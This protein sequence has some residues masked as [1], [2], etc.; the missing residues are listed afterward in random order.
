MLT[1]KNNFLY[2]ATALIVLITM[3]TYGFVINFQVNNDEL[4]DSI[5]ILKEE[6]INLR[7]K[8]LSDTSMYKLDQK[9]QE[10]NM[11]VV[12]Q[13][14]IISVKSGIKS[15]LSKVLKKRRKIDFEREYI[16]GGY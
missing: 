12:N 8:Y 5:D 11:S 16:A 6:K 14:Q 3:L 2:Y 1:E 15:K 4:R 10:M 13:N 9:A 7:A